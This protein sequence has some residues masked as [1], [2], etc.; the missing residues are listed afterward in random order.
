MQS[1]VSVVMMD[2]DNVLTK[3]KI[4]KHVKALDY[5]YTKVRNKSGNYLYIVPKEEPHK[6][7]IYNRGWAIFY[8]QKKNKTPDS[9]LY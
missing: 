8:Y 9:L 4:I 3:Q 5:Q 1:Y 6:L 7:S 2:A